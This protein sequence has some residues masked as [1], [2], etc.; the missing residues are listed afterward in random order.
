MKIIRVSNTTL[1]LLFILFLCGYIKVGITIFLI[2]LIGSIHISGIRIN[3]DAIAETSNIK[4]YFI[5]GITD[6]LKLL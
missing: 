4:K 6:S 1:Y 2:V 5:V 3:S